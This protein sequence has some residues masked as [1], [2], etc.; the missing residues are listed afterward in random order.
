MIRKYIN[1]INF[2]KK[3]RN[4]FSKQ[5]IDSD[6]KILIEIFDHPPSQ[7]SYSYFS[8]I[9]SKLK[10]SKIVS[11]FPRRAKLKNY[12]YNLFFPFSPFS[13][14]KSYGSTQIVNPKYNKKIPDKIIKTIKT[15]EDILKIV[16]KKIYIGDLIYDEYLV[17][18][19]K[20]TIDF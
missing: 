3:N 16:L 8:N 4:F 10:I 11:I 18:Y 15:K 19:K 1:I 9:L 14:Q 5:N 17:K 7:I 13:I 6:N 2:K 20:S 12:L